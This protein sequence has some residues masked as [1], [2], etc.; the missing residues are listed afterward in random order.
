[1]KIVILDLSLLKS[2]VT[3]GHGHEENI[4]RETKDKKNIL[5]LLRFNIM[6]L[7]HALHIRTTQKTMYLGF[8]NQNPTGIEEI[9]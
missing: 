8:T 4:E 7:Y 6:R 5:R 1:M 3:A 2:T 9:L